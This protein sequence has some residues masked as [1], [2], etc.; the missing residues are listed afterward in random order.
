MGD[1]IITIGLSPCWDRTIEIA[2]INWNQHKTTSSQKR[3]PAGKALNINKALAW[4]E[5][6]STA[7]GL[8]GSEDFSQ[9][10]QALTC[11]SRSLCHSRES[12]N[13]RINIRL[14]KVPGST[15]ENITIIDTANKR[16]MHLRSKSTLAN[17]KTT[18]LLER[19]LQKIIIKHS[20]CIFSGAMPDEAIELVEFAKKKAVSVIVDTS[21]P[22]LKRIVAKGG[23]F[24]I[25]PNIEELGELVGKKIKNEER[26]IISA[27]KKLLTKVKFI[28]VS[29]GEKGAM[30]IFSHSSGEFIP[31]H[32]KGV[33]QKILKAETIV[34]S[35]KYIGKK[36]DVYNTVGCGDYLLA[37]FIS[38]FCPCID[39][40][41]RALKDG[42]QAATAKAF[43]LNETLS[44]QQIQKKINIKILHL[45]KT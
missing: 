37:G 22:V 5:I 42:V 24:L 43:G 10:K 34:L 40:C 18:K 9:M 23:L 14:T 44:W 8:W 21:G 26:A 12:G 30:L 25:K 32:C 36:Y 38:R 33:P 16:Q 29:R 13:P 31:E 35:A 20:I 3:A 19:D 27:A 28:L 45:R 2:D 4:M 15:R 41:I 11:H 6:E 39:N 17:G 1:E 7:A